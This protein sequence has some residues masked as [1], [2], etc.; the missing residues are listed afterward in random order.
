VTRWLRFLLVAIRSLW[1]PRLEATG[2]ATVTARVWPTDAD[3]TATNNAAYLV[4]LEMARIDL[5][6][7]TGLLRLATRKRW[8]A[9]MASI[10]VR[11]RKPLRRFQRFQVSARLVYWDEK[12][13]YLAQHIEREGE[14]VA[15]A[16]A[17]SL[18]LGPEGRVAPTDVASALGA[19]LGVPP[20]PPVIE[21]YEEAERLIGSGR[22]P[23]PASTPAQRKG[24]EGGQLVP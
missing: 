12:W 10:H 6:L 2:T 24:Q 15:T 5:Q 18:V 22:E 14:V 19:S 20:K 11:F 8:A 13:L 23:G 9:P 21:H 7:R 1:R 17:K 3:V 16:L 4:Y